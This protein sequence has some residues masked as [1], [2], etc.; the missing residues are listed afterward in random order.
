[1]VYDIK[2]DDGKILSVEIADPQ[3]NVK[4][5][6]GSKVSVAFKQKSLHVLPYEERGENE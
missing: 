6:V 5:S 4:Y 1:M 2:L 3:D